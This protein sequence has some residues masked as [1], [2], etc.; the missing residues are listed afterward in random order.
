MEFGIHTASTHPTELMIS[1]QFAIILRLG[2]TVV[3]MGGF[4]LGICLSLWRE[5]TWVMALFRGAMV[6]IISALLIRW[7][8]LSL[9][10]A[11]L[12]QVVIRKR[13]QIMQAKQAKT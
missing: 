1:N 3:G 12:E 10:R 5:T 7:L 6:C 9:F 11:H 2:M 8:L 4:F 13:N